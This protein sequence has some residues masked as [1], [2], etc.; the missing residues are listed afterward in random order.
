MSG[1]ISVL[2][3]E[4]SVNGIEELVHELN[5]TDGLFKFVRVMRKKF[6]EAVAQGTTTVLYIF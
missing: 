1:Y 6:Q 5:K 2:R 4:P 3:C